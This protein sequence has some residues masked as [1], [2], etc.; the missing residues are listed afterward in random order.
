MPVRASRLRLIL[1]GVAGVIV[2]AIVVLQLR[3]TPA[4]EASPSPSPSSAPSSIA[5]APSVTE[6]TTTDSCGNKHVGLGLTNLR[7]FV[8]LGSGTQPDQVAAEEKFVTDLDRKQHCFNL[9][10]EIVPN[11]EAYDTLKTEIALGKAPDIIGPVGAIGLNGLEGLLADLSPF[12]AAQKTDLT[13]FDP[14]VLD[15][16]KGDYGQIGLPYDIYPGYIFYNKDLFEKA[17]LPPLPDGVGE[18][19][20]GKEW[21]WDELASVAAKLTTDKNGKNATQAGFDPHNIVRYGFD[22]GYA[23]AREFASAFGAGAVLPGSTMAQL[24]DSWVHA[25]NWY[26]DAAWKT[27][28][29]AA[30][31]QS[32]TLLLNPPSSPAA[33]GRA[34]MELS[35]PWEIQSFADTNSRG[36]TYVKNWDIGVLPSYNGTTT[37]PMFGDTFAITK[38]AKN[39]IYAYEAMIYVMAD[40][41]LMKM[42]GGVPARIADQKS[43]FAALDA[44]L[45][46]IFPGNQVTWPVI[47]EMASHAAKP[48][49]QAGMPADAASKAL[50]AAFWQKLRRDS[51]VDVTAALAKLSTD[52]QAVFDTVKPIQ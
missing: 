50:L 40:P 46:P 37:S 17:G 7:W 9:T 5:K 48:S 43:Y 2:M 32:Q 36:H 27:H 18:P 12:I 35:W 3:P 30:E 25:W 14:A 47:D 41:A 31:N 1:A 4:P 21:T 38:A 51:T 26:Y 16:W 45:A 22:T 8:G 24:P 11:A 20:Q 34:A 42:Y 6:D 29:A 15:F 13:A 28:A 52:L 44:T 39:P 23:D 10:I 49:P 19:Y 33:I